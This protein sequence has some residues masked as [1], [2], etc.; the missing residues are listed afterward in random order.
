LKT[1][2][3][4]EIETVEVGNDIGFVGTV[5]LDNA[6][7]QYYILP[8]VEDLPVD[9]NDNIALFSFSDAEKISLYKSG[10]VT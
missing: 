8:C 2:D 4:K 1:I 6:K 5:W 9:D 3:F 10:K 7:E